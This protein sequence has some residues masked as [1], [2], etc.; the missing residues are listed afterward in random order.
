MVDFSSELYWTHAGT[1]GNSG[2]IYS[3]DA[4]NGTRT[5]NPSVLNRVVC[6]GSIIGIAMIAELGHCLMD[7][8]H[9]FFRASPTG[10]A[11]YMIKIK[12]DGK[13][14][15]DDK[16]GT[17]CGWNCYFKVFTHIC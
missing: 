11:D 13:W 5:R 6:S 10:D 14:L 4:N 3:K 8:L 9:H 2:E 16:F 1:P 12:A 7:F 17:Y 15:N